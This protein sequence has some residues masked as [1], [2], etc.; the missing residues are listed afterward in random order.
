[1]K[2]VT[3]IMFALMVATSSGAVAGPFNDSDVEPA[4]NGGV[5]ASGLFP[6][7]DLEDRYGTKAALDVEYHERDMEPAFN[8]G[9]SASGLF[10]TQEAEDRASE[11]TKR[12]LFEMSQNH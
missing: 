4:F 8:G 9:V 7:Q 3:P 2:S 11:E 12:M 1:M 6:T 10:P 5:S